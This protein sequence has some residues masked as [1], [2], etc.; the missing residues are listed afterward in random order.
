MG[1]GGVVWTVAGCRGVAWGAAGWGRGGVG[2]GCG[3]GIG[4]GGLDQSGWDGRKG[5]G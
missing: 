4:V 5:G 1:F 3:R 2:G